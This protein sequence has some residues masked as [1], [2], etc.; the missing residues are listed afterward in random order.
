MQTKKE[1]EDWHETED[2]WG[3]KT[4]PDDWLRKQII[5]KLATIYAGDAD[6]TLDLGAG[7]GWITKDLPGEHKFGVELSDRA[8]R[9]FP[10]NVK[11]IFRPQGGYDLIIATGVLY[12][13]YDH[14]KLLDWVKKHAQN[15]VLTCNIKD[16][17]I[18]DLP[19]D[20]QIFYAEFPYR[21][22]E[23]VLR[24]YKW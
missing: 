2:A 24:I 1:L 15:I 23:Q 7:E 20:K 10:E 21:E 19:E 5:I 13:Q 3:Y 17:E 16:W 14:A 6:T 18:N 22:Y 11:R 4:N 8:A 9:R 12:K